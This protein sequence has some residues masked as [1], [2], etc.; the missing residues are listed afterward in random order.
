MYGIIQGGIYEDLREESIEF[1]LKHSFFGMAIG[2]TLGSDK[3]QMYEVVNFT[4]KKLGNKHPVH[5]LGIGAA[6]VICNLI[7][8]GVDTFDCVMPTRIARHGASL[9]RYNSKGKINIKNSIYREDQSSLEE[10]CDC[11]TC[12]NYS[13]SY[14]HHLFKSNEILGLQLLSLHNVFFMNFMMEKIREA[15]LNDN[16]EEEKKRW[17]N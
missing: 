17:F 6:V 11:E 10:G 16:L 15:I 12:L 14:I 4:S 7:D 1:N 5:L 2:G 3:A 9:T 8:S 13:R